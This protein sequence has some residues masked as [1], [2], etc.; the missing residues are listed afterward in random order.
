MEKQEDIPICSFDRLKDKLTSMGIEIGKAGV[1]RTVGTVNVLPEDIGKRILF[2]NNGIYYID[3]DG[4]K[5]RGF[6]YKAAFYFEWQGTIN[7]PRFHVCQCPA[8]NSF[9][10][11]AYRFANAE[12]VKIYSRNKKREVMVEGLELCGF[13]ANMM[14]RQEVSK[15]INST[16][17]VDI[18]KK[19]GDVKEPE[20]LELDIFGYTKDWPEISLAYRT[21]HDFTCERC[22]V[23]VLND[24]DRQ[25]MQ[26]HHKNG[27]KKDNRVQ[28]LEC[29]CI[30]CHSEVD[31]AHRHNFSKG[32]NKYFLGD[33]MSKYHQSKNT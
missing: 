27:D 5:R 13:C 9:G 26:T 1:W 15:V 24:F 30:K 18:L 7:H 2:E 12:P 10:K 6:M 32:G 20:E 4:I 3:S 11:D 28:N 22:G 16:D 29:L 21:K 33:F 19:A 25:F 23:H 14:N 31:D 17:F 8:I